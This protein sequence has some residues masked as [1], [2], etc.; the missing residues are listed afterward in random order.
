MAP[1]I[2]TLLMLMVDEWSGGDHGEETP[3]ISLL[4]FGDHTLQLSKQN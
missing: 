2:L 4:L 1:G 3:Q